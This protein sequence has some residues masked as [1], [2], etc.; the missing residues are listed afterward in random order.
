MIYTP[1]L[2]KSIAPSVFA[3][4]PSSKMTKKYTFVPTDQVM[5]FFDR[6]GWQISS[7]KQTGRGIMRW[8][9]GGSSSSAKEAAHDLSQAFLALRV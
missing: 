2:I 3:T 7:V 4:E 8:S 6:E 1:E 5:E 9:E